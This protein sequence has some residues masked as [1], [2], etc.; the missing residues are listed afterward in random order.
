MLCHVK[1]AAMISSVTRVKSSFLKKELKGFVDYRGT[2]W[3]HRV[4]P[5]SFCQFQLHKQPDLPK[6]DNQWLEKELDQ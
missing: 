6:S 1:V 5:I 3:G 4:T 2:E